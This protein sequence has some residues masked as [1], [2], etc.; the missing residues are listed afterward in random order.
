MTVEW[1]DQSVARR[2]MPVANPAGPE[3][4]ETHRDG[5]S[6]AAS[7]RPANT[8]SG[9]ELSG[10][11]VDPVS[12]FTWVIPPQPWTPDNRKY[13][14]YRLGDLTVTADAWVWLGE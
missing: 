3:W 2:V 1:A 14:A 11:L 12:G 10:R 4:A 7:L 8:A 5:S 6:A 9:W 13:Q